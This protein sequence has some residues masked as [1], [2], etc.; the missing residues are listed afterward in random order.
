MGQN[1][2]LVA[3]EQG[4]ARRVPRGEGR[5]DAIEV[6]WPALRDGERFPAAAGVSR[7]VGTVTAR[8]E[9]VS[10][11]R[12]DPGQHEAEDEQPDAQNHQHR[13]DPPSP[14]RGIRPG[15]RHR[16]LLSWL[17]RKRRGRASLRR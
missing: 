15:I 16:R 9:S 1:P 12:A 6:G 14:E 13:S 4:E 7:E 3:E 10:E 2:G 11:Q 5:D 8:T 17:H